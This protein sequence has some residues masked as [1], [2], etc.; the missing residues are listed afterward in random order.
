MKA[1]S[2]VQ[3]ALDRAKNVE[4]RATAMEVTLLDANQ[5]TKEAVQLQ[6]A[7]DMECTSLRTKAAE[8]V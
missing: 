6:E 7:S 8:L 1:E 3:E 2:V 5:N 4:K